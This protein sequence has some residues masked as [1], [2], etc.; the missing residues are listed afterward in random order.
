MVTDTTVR[1]YQY[2]E[3]TSSI[4]G[5]VQNNN[6]KAGLESSFND[7]LKGKEGKEIYIDRNSTK[8][9]TISKIEKQDGKDDSMSPPALRLTDSIEISRPHAAK[10]ANSARTLKM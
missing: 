6:G 5:Y 9:K 3:A 1:T 2:K 10:A 7:I 4:T 8:V